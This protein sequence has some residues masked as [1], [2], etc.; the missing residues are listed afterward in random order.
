[1]RIL[2]L[3]AL[4]FLAACSGKKG[5]SNHSGEHSST[6]PEGEA[7]I[8]D[9]QAGKLALMEFGVSAV[10]AQGDFLAALTESNKD[11]STEPGN[12]ALSLGLTGFESGYEDN[13][14]TEFNLNSSGNYRTPS[15]PGFSIASA[16]PDE[17]HIYVKKITLSYRASGQTE[18]G[19]NKKGDDGMQGP[20]SLKANHVALF[21]NLNDTQ[22]AAVEALVG[23]EFAD[24]D[25]FGEAVEQASGV[26]MEELGNIFESRMD[27]LS[28]GVEPSVTS[29]V[30]APAVVDLF[31]DE[32]GKPIKLVNGTADLS[33]L[34]A[35]TNG[36][37]AQFEVPEGKYN[38]LTISYANKAKVKGCVKML[39]ECRGGDHCT[40]NKPD[41]DIPGTSGVAGDPRQVLL[42]YCTQ[43]DDSLY[44]GKKTQNKDFLDKA[45]ELMDFPLEFHD[46]S[47][48][49]PE[50]KT[51]SYALPSDI[52]L[53]AGEGAG[54]ITLLVDL[55][56]MLRY[57]NRGRPN[58]SFST[59]GP[60][61]RSYFFTSIF[62]ESTYA[63]IGKPGRIY[64]FEMRTKACESEKKDKDGNSVT[65]AGVYNSSTERCADGTE[66]TGQVPFWMTIITSPS[67][68][69]LHM[70][71]SPDDDNDLT[72]TKGSIT[73]FRRCPEQGQ[74]VPWVQADANSNPQTVSLLFG[75]CENDNGL[76]SNGRYIGFPAAL[77]GI[78]VIAPNV[79]LGDGNISGLRIKST[80]KPPEGG[81]FIYE[82]PVV[83]TRRL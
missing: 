71:T 45:P 60:T 11:A 28:V 9:I 63:F 2:L 21:P 57:Y 46:A 14:Y 53:L 66:P 34:A 23:Q 38:T 81:Y 15:L 30:E 72:I 41:E 76:G 49:L 12:L 73:A 24:L 18:D 48:P 36:G 26:D 6:D 27:E 20:K 47:K 19:G 13:V 68:S 16:A 35:A 62:A 78:P 75:L 67:G 3:G 59:N 82:G 22:K 5:G 1:M 74:T 25:S 7:D 54:R 83:V 61:D 33:A 42:T 80:G 55:N 8:G 79:P 29:P 65:V 40:E 51:I 50:T 32:V 31:V 44:S 10:A 4:V 52:E 58:Q 43:A 77:D 56:R 17:M 39:Y 69:P 70:L 37:A 64:G